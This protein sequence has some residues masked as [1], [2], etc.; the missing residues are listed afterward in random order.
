MS[1]EL[2]I[3]AWKKANRHRHYKESKINFLWNSFLKAD[4]LNLWAIQMKGSNT[5]KVVLRKE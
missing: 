4:I 5:K 1:W 2:I 3:L